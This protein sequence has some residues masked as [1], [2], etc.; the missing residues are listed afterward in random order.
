IHWR[1][2]G[3]SGRLSP[4]LNT[5]QGRQWLYSWVKA[6]SHYYPRTAMPNLFLDPIAVTDPSGHPTGR[7]TDP[8]ADIREYL[9]SVPTD[10][11][12]EQTTPAA[13]LSPDEMAA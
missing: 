2:C 4:R 1:Q 12:P 10:W 7:T 8:A 9:L 6:P 3:A 5:D 13:D 11:K